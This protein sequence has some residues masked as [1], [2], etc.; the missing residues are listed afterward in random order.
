MNIP[1]FRPGNRP[2]LLL[3]P[4][5]VLSVLIGSF[6]LSMGAAPPSNRLSVYVITANNQFGVVNLATGAFHEI[7]PLTPEGQANL[8][9]W[10]GS[11]LS[12]TFSGELEKI[13]P[14]TGETS[15]IG[16]TGLGVNA[17]DLGEVRGKLYATDFSNN[18]YSV[19]PETGGATF[20]RATGISP[21]PAVPFSANGDGTINLFDESLYGTAG[22]LY[23][24]FDA[25]TVNPTTL[26]ET[27]DSE[28]PDFNCCGP[29]LY[30]LDPSTGVATAIGPTT[31][32]IGSTVEVNGE[33][34]AFRW[35][36]TGCDPCAPAAD[37]EPQIK[38]QLLRL[39]LRTGNTTPVENAGGPIFVDAAAGGIEG[40]A[41][42]FGEQKAERTH[43]R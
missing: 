39:D 21:I 1:A 9:W 4:A 3:M 25:F 30:Q 37:F 17:V 42:Y 16:P 38:S 29:T 31:L 11:L 32:G 7:G 43:W 2:Q 23:A 20:L 26:V 15:D 14:A 13:N 34:Y 18:I 27:P 10:N 22:K 12:L 19:N 24:T 35:V 6:A 28:N 41:P 8:V 36:G 5:L 40:A 33:F